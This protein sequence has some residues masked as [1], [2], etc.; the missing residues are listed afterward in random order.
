MNRPWKETVRMNGTQEL[1]TDDRNHEIIQARFRKCVREGNY[2]EIANL[3]AASTAFTTTD[4][5]L[6][7]SVMFYTFQGKRGVEVDVPSGDHEAFLSNKDYTLIKSGVK[8]VTI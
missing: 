1:K 3:Q 6:K 7:E 4:G 8:E 2:D 5:V